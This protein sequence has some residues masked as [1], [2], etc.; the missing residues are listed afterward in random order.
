MN[1][2]WLQQYL[3]PDNN[4]HNE[5]DDDYDQEHQHSSS[6]SQLWV[7]PCSGGEPVVKYVDESTLITCDC[8]MWLM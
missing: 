1:A 8:N 4:Q 3:F 2:D 5:W 6:Y 7:R